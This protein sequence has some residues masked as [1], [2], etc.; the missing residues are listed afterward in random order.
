MLVAPPIDLTNFIGRGDFTKKRHEKPERTEEEVD[1]DIMR[2]QAER[3]IA[4][5]SIMAEHVEEIQ[6][7]LE[8]VQSEEAKSARFDK[9]KKSSVAAAAC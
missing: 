2:I 9:M 7:D 8:T 3:L 1:A 4:P 6:A 5:P